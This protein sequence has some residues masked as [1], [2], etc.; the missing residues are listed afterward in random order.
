MDL[1]L[2]AKSIDITPKGPV[3][4]SG[5]AARNGV[6]DKVCDRLEINLCALRYD[7]GYVLVYSVDTLF[8]P[9][10]FVQIVLDKFG[11][12]YGIKEEQIWM[13]ATH[14]HFAPSL[15]KEK[16]ALGVCDD[17]YYQYVVAQL[18]QLTEE[19]LA[20]TYKK[21]SVHHG[22]ATST[23]NVNRR[24]KLLRPNSGLSLKK[25]VL[26]YPNYEGVKD[27]IIHS[28]ILKGEDGNTEMVLW[29]YACHPVGF[30]PRNGVSADYIGAVRKHVRLHHK[31]ESLP[32]IFLIGFA[33]N[34]KPDVTP[35]TGTKQQDQLRYML[36]LAPKYTRFPNADLYKQW[37][38]LLWEEVKQAIASASEINSIDIQ[39][40]EYKIPLGDIIGKQADELCFKRLRL[41]ENIQLTGI[42][43]E[44]FAE[45]KDYTTGINIGCLAGTRI[46]LPTDECIAEGGYEVAEFKDKFGVQG[47]FK[48]DVTDKIVAALSKL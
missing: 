6:Y 9:E 11:N 41:T 37:T 22:K 4:L 7:A 38:E 17:G 20:A 45:Y 33:G 21:V 47:V 14:T 46:Y 2:S 15:D 16:P 3:P 19:V 42:S 32:V 35:V 27:D 23:L 34:L 28:L 44:V 39:A 5:F 1:F 48:N 30:I 8:V 13:A 12:K 36:Q 24:K 43:A 18:I 40:S 10:C 25:K 31:E 29:N 26:M